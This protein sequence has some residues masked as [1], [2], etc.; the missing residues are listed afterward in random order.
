MARSAKAA[1]VSG[2]VPSA[3][4]EAATAVGADSAPATE[5]VALLSVVDEFPPADA[6]G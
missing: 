5:P 2:V 6:A 3:P 1:A 4:D